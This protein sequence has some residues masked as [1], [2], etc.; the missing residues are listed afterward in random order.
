[1]RVLVIDDVAKTS[2][3]N[4]KEFALKRRHTIHDVMRRK[5]H[6][7]DTPGLDANYSL[8]LFDGW[9]VVYTVE[10][11]TSGWFHHIS[12]SIDPREKEKPC[13]SVAGVEE[14]LKLF[15]LGP[16]SKQAGGWLENI[17]GGKAINL[18]FPFV[19][20]KTA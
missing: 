12:I 19:E 18:L 3:A 16:V 7:E 6:P 8:E 11:S 4:V 5:C 15:G 14:I 1:M 13:P 2:A 9:K 17:E 10:Q 20:G